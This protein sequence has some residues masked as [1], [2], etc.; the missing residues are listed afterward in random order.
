MRA[1][2]DA[3]G[4]VPPGLPDLLQLLPQPGGQRLAQPVQQLGQL[5]VVLPVVAR[6]K[7]SGLRG[8]EK[9]TKIRLKETHPTNGLSQEELNAFSSKA[10]VSDF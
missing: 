6:Q 2:R 5:H 7:R 1:G 10:Q 3:P 8:G 9:Q 4:R